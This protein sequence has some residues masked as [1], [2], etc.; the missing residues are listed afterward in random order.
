MLDSDDDTENMMVDEFDDNSF[1]EDKRLKPTTT[2]KHFTD[3][4]VVGALDAAKVSKDHAIRI[5]SAVALALG[6]S[7]DDLV[8]SA[9]TI[10]RVR[11]QMRQ[12][13]SCSIKTQFKA[14][15]AVIHFDTKILPDIVGKKKVDRM[16]VVCSQATGDQLLGI[17]KIQNGSGENQAHAVYKLLTE[18]NV[19]NDVVAFCTDT[20]SSNTGCYNGAIVL[21]QQMLGRSI[22]YFGCRHHVYEILL[23]AAFE[24]K[25]GGTSSPNVPIFERFR[26]SWENFDQHEFEPGIRDEFVESCLTGV[27]DE[28]ADY[29]ANELKKKIVR[30]DYKE[31]LESGLFFLDKQTDTMVFRVPG[32]IHHARWMAKSIYALKMYLFSS[33]FDLTR[34]QKKGLA[35][36][37]VFIVRHYVKAW[38]QCN[39]NNNNLLKSVCTSVLKYVQ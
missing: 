39:N 33:Q 5:I 27:V 1:S 12:S 15:N 10:Q 16:P 6:H 37:C 4:R 25:F 31:F 36:L 17:P 2:K 20:T 18:W 24:S 26:N 7:L 3:A 13:A 29:C 35:E 9:N 32:A 14:K 34:T 11:M 28:I 21:L 30:R 8:V 38:F 19:C 23:R 22:L